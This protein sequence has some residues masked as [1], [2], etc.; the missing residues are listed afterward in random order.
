MNTLGTFFLTWSLVTAF[1]P[2]TQYGIYSNEGDTLGSVKHTAAFSTELALS[3]TLY[4][5]VRL[6]T[7]IETHEFL[8]KGSSLFV[9]Y[10][11]YFR[12]GAAIFTDHLE[13]GLKHEC[14]HGISS[15]GY[16]SPWLGGG[17]TSLYLKLSGSTFF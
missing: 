14:D 11:S 15:A 9:P 3:A 6:D 1:L 13:L 12:I 4:N 5:H 17:Y 8:P 7:S 10:Q 2:S 16:P